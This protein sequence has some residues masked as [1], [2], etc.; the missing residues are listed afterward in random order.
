MVHSTRLAKNVNYLVGYLVNLA[1]RGGAEQ[2]GSRP[3]EGTRPAFLCGSSAAEGDF[4][5]AARAALAL[6]AFL[7]RRANHLGES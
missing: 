4:E 1:V 7:D 6:T 3:A 5:A 2:R